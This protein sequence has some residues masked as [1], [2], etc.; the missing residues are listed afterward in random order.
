MNVLIAGGTGFLGKSLLSYLAGS[1]SKISKLFILSRTPEKLQQTFELNSFPFPIILVKQDIREHIKINEPIDKIIHA[2]SESSTQL[3]I[4]NPNASREI[5]LGGTRNILEF[6]K[7]VGVKRLL[8]V[9]SGAVYGKQP[10]ELPRLSEDYDEKV[11][12]N[13]VF[14]NYAKDKRKAESQCL[15]FGISNGMEIL[16]ARCF[17]FI[18]PYLPLDAHYAVGNFIRDGLKGGPIKIKGDGTPYRSYLYADDLAEWLWTILTKGESGEIYNVGS[19]EAVTIAE[20]AEMVSRN[21][22]NHTK[23][24]ITNIPDSGIKPDRYVPDITKAT[25]E[26]YL[27]VKIPLR[28]ALLKT[29]DYHL[30]KYCD[31]KY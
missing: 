23:V 5:I 21:F 6:S 19:N 28:E 1:N 14:A 18:G 26:L 2:A 30:R 11:S 8:Y 9:S 24:E 25:Q 13:Y 27:K 16:I 4:K 22:K 29:T 10:T 3:P 31:I 15:N 20:L 7:K 17:S 12:E